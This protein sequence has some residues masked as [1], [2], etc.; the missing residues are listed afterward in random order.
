MFAG[1]PLA[2]SPPGAAAGGRVA[3]PRPASL[4]AALLV[5]VSAT[6]AAADVP[7]TA[8]R[9]Y[10]PGGPH[11]A[12]SKCATRYREL[13]GEVVLVYK[14]GPGGSLSRHVAMD[15][16][17]YYGG[18]DFML[19]EFARSNPGVLDLQTVERL[20]PRRVGIVVRR[21]NPLG[22]RGLEDLYRTDVSVLKA[23]L[24]RVSDFHDEELCPNA[25]PHPETHSGSDALKAWRS[26]PEIDAWI[27][28]RSWHA[29]LAQEADFVE[30]PDDS[31][32]RFTPIAITAATP[33]REAA[34]K[35]I[36]FLKSPEA[37]R[38]FRE[39]GWE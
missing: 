8:L 19:E 31:A 16:D 25:S 27:T 33:H 24:E 28:Y 37:R 13:H 35:F 12:L 22:I 9:V 1:I 17:L 20:H 23:S 39:H 11:E 2:P 14:A 26:H 38:I 29:V 18:A 36:A 5:A 10:G 4:L 30:I 32:V 21:G 7:H 34:E 6:G 15:G 3:R